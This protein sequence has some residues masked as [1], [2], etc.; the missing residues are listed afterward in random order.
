MPEPRIRLAAAS[1]LDGNIYAIGGYDPSTGTAVS[2]VVRYNPIENTWSI[3]ASLP[4]ALLAAIAVRGNDGR[5]YVFGGARDAS[6]RTNEDST[7]AYDPSTDTWQTL[8]PMPTARYG[9]SAAVGRDG[10]IYVIGGCCSDAPEMN[11]V[12]AYD[13]VTDTWTELSPT[14]TVGIAFAAAVSAGKRIYVFGGAITGDSTSV[15]QIYTPAKD[16]WQFA[17]FFMPA[18]RQSLGAG[19]DASGRIYVLGGFDTDDVFLSSVDVFTPSTGTW[20]SGPPMPKARAAF[21][22]ASFDDRIHVLGGYSCFTCVQGRNNF[23]LTTP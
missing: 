14:A 8:A 9:A 17:P 1:D 3:M 21:G 11:T 15:V 23:V 19:M 2:T 13:P 4:E 5:I 6:G 20:Q 10:R 22:I 16:Q 12:E 7:E 18:A